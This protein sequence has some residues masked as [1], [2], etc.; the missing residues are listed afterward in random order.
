MKKPLIAL[1]AAALLLAAAGCAADNEAGDSGSTG[2]T[3]AAASPSA[4]ATATPSASGTPSGSPSPSATASAP[5]IAPG[6]PT[7][8]LPIMPDSTPLATSFETDDKLFTASLTATTSA[9][10]DAVLAYYAAE[11]TAQGFTPTEA[12]NQGSATLRQFVR[13]GGEEIANVTVVP[14]EGTATYTVSVNTLAEPAK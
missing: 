11:F 6:F 10:T 9:S 5:P 8:V 3:S 14:R 2:S 7:D 1:T 4:S 12:E 13:S